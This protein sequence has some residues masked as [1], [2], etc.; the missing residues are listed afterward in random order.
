MKKK[1]LF[2][3]ALL[4]GSLM[5]PAVLQTAAVVQADEFY[6][7]QSTAQAA[8]ITNW[9]ASSPEQIKQNMQNQNI[10]VDQSGT[11]VDSGQDGQIYVIQWGDTLWGISQA[12]GISIAKLAYDNNIQNVDLIYAGD[13]LILKRDGQVPV[14]Y[15]YNGNGQHCAMTKVVINNYIHNGNNY[16]YNDNSTNLHLT[17][18]E[19]TTFKEVDQSRIEYKPEI[20]VGDTLDWKQPAVQEEEVK[21]EVNDEPSMTELFPEDNSDSGSSSSPSGDGIVGTGGSDSTDSS[22][23]ESSTSSTSSSNSSSSSSSTS[24]NANAT[25][26][27]TQ[28][29]SS[30]EVL[31]LD[32]Y[33]DTIQAEIRML[34]SKDTS[35][36]QNLTLNFLDNKDEFNRNADLIADLDM[37][38]LYKPRAEALLTDVSKYTESSAKKVAEEIYA[39]LKARASE[40]ADAK[41]L[42]ITLTKESGRD[43]FNVKVY[44]E[45]EESSSSSSLS[46]SSSAMTRTSSSSDDYEDFD[47]S[48]SESTFSRTETS[49]SSS[50]DSYEE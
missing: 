49:I 5:T 3:T 15:K 30:E 43:A 31:E 37:K 34:H 36:S 41:Y 17:N 9:I 12:T 19:N 11:V 24:S 40:L 35:V 46:S 29:S 23:T 6:Q 21:K 33:L 45:V 13:T 38:E 44:K 18:I 32:D 47:S 28:A 22:S 42:Q 20:K 16:V 4:L 7:Y 26:S 8:D 1:H 39:K 48:S 27:S 2:G 50:S 14:D 10:R 25:S